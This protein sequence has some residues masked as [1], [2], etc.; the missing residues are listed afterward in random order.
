MDAL[1]NVGQGGTGDEEYAVAIGA[2]G[3]NIG[4]RND[5]GWVAMLYAYDGGMSG[6]TIRQESPGV[7]GSAEAGGPARDRG[8]DRLPAALC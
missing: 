7:P 1:E 6:G 3:G 2:P 8:L 4:G 5:A